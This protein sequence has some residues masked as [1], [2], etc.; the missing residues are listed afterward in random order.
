MTARFDHSV[1]RSM[2]PRQMG[3]GVPAKWRCMGCD[4]VRGMTGSRGAGLRKRCAQCVAGKGA[5]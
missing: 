1:D 4:Q 3:A 5:A 2:R